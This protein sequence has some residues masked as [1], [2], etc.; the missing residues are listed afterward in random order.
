MVIKILGIGCSNCKKLEKNAKDAI[1]SLGIDAQIIKV[2]DMNEITQYGILRTPGL[3]V[4]D[5]IVS[6]G[7]VP[8][9]DEIVQLIS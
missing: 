5:K 6:F 9:V 1:E 3:V 7:R 2:T 4:D 8:S